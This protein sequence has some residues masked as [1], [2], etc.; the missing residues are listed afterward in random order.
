MKIVFVLFSLCVFNSAYGQTNLYRWQ[1]EQGQ[2]HFGDEASRQMRAAEPVTMAPETQNVV[3]TKVIK[4]PKIK[5][6][7]NTKVR[8][9][10][11]DDVEMSMRER[12]EW[13]HKEKQR[14]YLQ[15]LR[16]EEKCQYD[17]E[18]VRAVKW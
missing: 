13:C 1:D 11:K 14:L 18:C 7:K 4:L 15:G 17:R 16:A 5:P 6:E 9:K 2:W 3:K 10:I 12:K 8:Q